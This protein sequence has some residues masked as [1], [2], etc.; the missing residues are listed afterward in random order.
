MTTSGGA[1]RARDQ[2]TI[3]TQDCG[4]RCCRYLT[5]AVATPRAQDDWDEMRW[6][7]AHEGVLVTK[8][9]DGWLLHV[10]T[11]CKNLASDNA[12]RVH[13]HHMQTCK[14]Y[15]A[16]N[17]EFTGPLEYD[18]QLS[19]ELDLARYLERRRLKR[20]A[21]IARAIRRAARQRKQAKPR[22]LVPLAGLTARKRGG[23]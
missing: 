3:C 18:L 16:T 10:D 22:D 6:W 1:A 21:P 20:G 4:A 14:D 7:L 23:A 13:P 5:V 19:S 15:D 9:E 2:L 12:C 11:R 17:C 8:D